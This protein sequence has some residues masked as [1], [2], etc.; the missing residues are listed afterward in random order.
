MGGDSPGDSADGM[1]HILLEGVGL[2]CDCRFHTHDLNLSL[3]TQKE[4]IQYNLDWK[5]YWTYFY[6]IITRKKLKLK[7]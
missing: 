2:Y 4:I 7:M 1:Y 6:N 5:K 3:Y